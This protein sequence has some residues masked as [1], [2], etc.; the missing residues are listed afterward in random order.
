M[1]VCSV[2]NEVATI[3]TVNFNGSNIRVAISNNAHHLVAIIH[4]YGFNDLISQ[5]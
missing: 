1:E 4:I 5:L 3:L 2:R